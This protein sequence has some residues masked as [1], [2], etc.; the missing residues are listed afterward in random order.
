MM[1]SFQDVM[2]FGNFTKLGLCRCFPT[3]F[4]EHLR[5]TTSGLRMKIINLP[6]KCRQAENL[7]SCLD[8][9]RPVKYALPR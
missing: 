6:T 2:F 9:T 5:T 8:G 3:I 7:K 1:M 4:I